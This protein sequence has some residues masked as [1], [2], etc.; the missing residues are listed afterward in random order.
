[1]DVEEVPP[2]RAFTA[3]ATRLR[4]DQRRMAT[5]LMQTSRGK[6]DRFPHTATGVYAGRT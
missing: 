1:M 6:F 4:R 2:V 3:T 5:M